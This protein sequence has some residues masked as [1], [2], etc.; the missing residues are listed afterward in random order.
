MK[1]YEQNWD[2]ENNIT[3]DAS[4]W[5]Q[6]RNDMLGAFPAYQNEKSDPLANAINRAVKALDQLR[7]D[8]EGPAFLGKTQH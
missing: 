6:Y 2:L 5:A 3:T 7:P 4:N 1:T 8:A